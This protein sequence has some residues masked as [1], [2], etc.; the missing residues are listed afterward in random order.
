MV[1]KQEWINALR[2]GRYEQGSGSLR[3]GDTFCCLGV[4]C[5]L[6][7]SGAWELRSEAPG[8]SQHFVWSELYVGFASIEDVAEVLG[9]DEDTANEAQSMLASCNDRGSTFEE[10]AEILETHNTQ[11]EWSAFANEGSN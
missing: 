8:M 7:S 2:S 4:L 11:A 3:V 9:L 10:I 6:T 5:D 1:T